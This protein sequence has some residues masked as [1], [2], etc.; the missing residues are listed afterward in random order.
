MECRTTGC[1]FRWGAFGLRCICSAAKS[2]VQLLQSAVEFP[3]TRDH[4]FAR[5]WR[6][7]RRLSMT[8]CWLQAL[9]LLR[10]QVAAQQG[11]FMAKLLAS[12]KLAPD[13]PLPAE[14]RPFKYGHKGSLA[15]VGSDK[16]V[17]DVPGMGP[18]TGFAAGM[19]PRPFHL[20]LHVCSPRGRL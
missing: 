18:I 12:G 2:L 5:C 14:V 7:W 16:A 8:A 11:K 19:P 17:M 13:K 4:P 15:Y 6:H 20:C 1:L 10:P 9:W 3:D